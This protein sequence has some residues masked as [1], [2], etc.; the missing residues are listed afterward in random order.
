MK[1]ILQDLFD[2][3][4]TGKEMYR[5]IETFSNDLDYIMIISSG[6]QSRFSDLDLITAF[7]T[8]RNIPYRQDQAPV[9]V[10]ARP[11]YINNDTGADCKKKAVLM[12]SYLKENNIPYRLVA[13][14]SRPDR[15]IHHVFTQGLI[16][17]EWK[18]LDP[19]YPSYKPFEHKEFTKLEVLK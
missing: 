19:T 12:G 18:N 8:I 2:K 11:M 17:G 6:S 1:M 15:R 16:N 7:N 3:K 5:I 13:V 4:Q 10:V 9:E 14:S